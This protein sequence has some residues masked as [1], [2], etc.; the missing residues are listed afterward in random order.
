[1][2]IGIAPQEEIQRVHGSLQGPLGILLVEEGQVV[3]QR[4]R[5][6]PDTAAGNLAD[7]RHADSATHEV[8]VEGQDTGR[9]IAMLHADLQGVLVGQRPGSTCETVRQAGTRLGGRKQFLG[10]EHRLFI[11]LEVAL[12]DGVTE[13]C[14]QGGLDEIGI[15]V[16]KAM[17]PDAGDHVPLDGAICQLHERS[18]TESRAH[19]WVEGRATPHGFKAFH[20]L[21]TYGY[22]PRIRGSDPGDRRLVAFQGPYQGFDGLLDIR[23]VHEWV[24]VLS[25]LGRFRWHE[26]PHSTDSRSRLSRFIRRAGGMEEG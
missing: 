16:T 10:K 1:M 4:I 21:I 22:S 3:N 6:E 19:V 5:G 20:G 17:D 26:S 8:V 9:T 15:S 14:S 12:H 24:Q 18:T 25:C 2:L 11:A 7:L 13:G 23:A